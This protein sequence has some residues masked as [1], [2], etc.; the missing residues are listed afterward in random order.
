MAVPTLALFFGSFLLWVIAALVVIDRD[1]SRLWLALTLPV[2]ALVTYGMFT[3]LHE[4]IH[5][6]VGR[7]KWLN[8]TIGR[9]AMPFVALWA[10]YPTMKFIH[11]EHHRHANDHS[12]KDPDAWATAGPRWL[13]PLR[14][15]SI[16]GQYA[17]F[18]LL[19]MKDRPRREKTWLMVN[20]VAVAA[21]LILL[22]ATGY[23]TDLV[24]LYL[25]P[26]RIGMGLL[27]CW[28]DWLP[29]HGLRATP[30]S[31]RFG[32]A[33]L[34]VG[35]EWL[36]NL[37]LIGQN[38]HLLHHIDPKTPFYRYVKQWRRNEADYLND[39][40]VITT[41]WGR[42]L[43]LLQYRSRRSVNRR[44]RGA[45]CRAL[46]PVD[47]SS[48]ATVTL[49]GVTTRF[50]TGQYESLLDAAL[51][52]GVAAPYLCME[53]VC[54][55]CKAKLVSGS[56]D[57]TSNRAPSEADRAEG[58]VLTCQSRI[59]SGSAHVDF[60]AQRHPRPVGSNLRCDHG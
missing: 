60:D 16:D 58:W 13:L 11:L 49:D 25:I 26:Q 34:R 41:L 50:T 33:R 42:E 23:G 45:D 10:T 53:G 46:A 19:H 39:S 1:F 4:S 8:G 22:V 18:Y 3:V 44:E 14:W 56:L 57:M 15:L 48:T 40:V 28:F 5:H 35:H 47:R 12:G 9:C 38:Y 27:A 2:Q 21:A 30:A 31:D 32:V 29:H 20:H 6:T 51:R 43:T 36:L 17:L 54:G 37:L 55:T 52:A 7:P 24:L 59:S